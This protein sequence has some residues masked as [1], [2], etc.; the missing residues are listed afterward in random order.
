M[1]LDQKRTRED[2]R[3]QR[4]RRE[5]EAQSPLEAEPAIGSAE[6]DAAR[7]LRIGLRRIELRFWNGSAPDRLKRLAEALR[8]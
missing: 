8:K 3:R 6:S 4:K 1:Q 5:P 7:A 2:Q